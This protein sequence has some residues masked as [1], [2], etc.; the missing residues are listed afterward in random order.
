[1]RLTEPTFDKLQQAIQRLCGLVITHDKQ[2]LIHDR[3]APVVQRHGWQTLEQLAERLALARSGE[4]VDD[5]VEAIVTRET[6]FFRDAHIWDALRRELLPRLVA[7]RT[8]VR[9][10]VRMWSAGT[11]TG[12]EAYTLAMLTLEMGTAATSP[13]LSQDRFSILATDICPSAVLAGKTGQYNALEMARG[14][15]AAR[16][17]RFFESCGAGWR[18]REPLRWMV[19][20]RRVN[21]TEPLPALGCFDLIC[22]RNVLIYFDQAMRR[23]ICDQFHHLLVEGGWLL[24]GASE[25]LYGISARF[26]SVTL[27]DAIVYRK[28]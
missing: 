16:R 8:A 25:N 28:S 4:L 3:L 12:Q 18:V 27:G 26:S 14:I 24:L 13:A 21:L 15:S 1:M 23:H 9:P 20:F 19:D 7:E 10:R 11:S 22:C 5:V 17:E 2:Y 6:S